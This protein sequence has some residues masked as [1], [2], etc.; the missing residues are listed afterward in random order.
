EFRSTHVFNIETCRG[1]YIAN[2]L[3]VKNCRAY[4]GLTWTYD[5]DQGKMKPV[6]HDKKWLGYPPLR[7]ACRSTTIP[8]M[9]KWSELS[10]MRLA[11]KDDQT[12]QEVFEKELG[13][14]GFSDDEIADIHQDQ[15]A[16][17]DGQVADSLTYEEWL[18][19]KPDQFQQQVLGQQRWRLWQDG[20]VNLAQM[21]D[22]DGNP[23]T[24]DELKQAAQDNIELPLAKADE[25]QDGITLA[26]RSILMA[27]FTAGKTDGQYNTTWIDDKTGITVDQS[28]THSL[29]AGEMDLLNQDGWGPI[30]HLSNSLSSNE[31]WDVSELKTWTA[32]ANFR[33]AKLVLGDGRIASV[34]LK[35]G[36]SWTTDDVQ[37]FQSALRGCEKRYGIR[38]DQVACAFKSTGKMSFAV[39]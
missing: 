11:H 13:D 14:Q 22:G 9:R 20:K 35:S 29:T 21:I 38:K 16:S 8:V 37:V 12:V 28:L 19:S 2:G 33:E 15:R 36:K 24:V 4:D 1:I 6:G 32:V 34:K 17:M 7:W 10:D 25:N 39:S 27:Q 18:K 3:I 31:Y 26:E 5:S 30:T 23:L